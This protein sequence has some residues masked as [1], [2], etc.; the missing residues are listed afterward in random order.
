MVVVG[1]C[2]GNKK[3]FHI[4]FN[5]QLLLGQ[6]LPSMTMHNHV[7]SDMTTSWT[8]MSLYTHPLPPF[9]TS[10]GTSIYTSW[11]MLL[12]L[13][14]V[15]FL[16]LAVMEHISGK[17]HDADDDSVDSMATVDVT[18]AIDN[19]AATT[20]VKMMKGIIH[21]NGVMTVNITISLVTI[22]TLQEQ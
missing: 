9:G 4:R 11:V 13:G 1:C 10:K 16:Q 20:T 7:T 17:Q 14:L 12:C 6:V 18:I 21:D 22:T 3:R 19:N 15:Q 2:F 8:L 5:I